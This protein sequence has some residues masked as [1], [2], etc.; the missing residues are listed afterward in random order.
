MAQQRDVSDDGLLTPTVGR[1]AL[2]KYRLLDLYNTLF[3]TGMKYR[4][5]LRVYIDLFCG[6]GRSRIRRTQRIVETSPLSALRVPDTFDKYIFCD[7]SSEAIVAL[8]QRV[9][10]D[11]S[12]VDADYLVGDCNNLVMEIAAR[13]PRGSRTRTALSFCFIDPYGISDIMFDTIRVLS[14]FRMDFL[15][16]LALAMDANRFQSLYV[17]ETDP[18]IDH[19][20]G[21]PSWRGRQAEARSRRIDFRRFLAQEFAARMQSLG[22]LRTGLER[23]KEVRSDER[24]LPLYHLAFFSKHERGY[25]FWEQVLRYGTDQLLLFG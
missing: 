7:K 17:K 21:D 5:N 1:W 2:Q 16:L 25:Q 20:L 3:S 8:R 11:F 13:I 9:E 19:F 10:R 24:N 22:Y 15:I 6:P 18:T 23:M 4:W 14:R 12:N